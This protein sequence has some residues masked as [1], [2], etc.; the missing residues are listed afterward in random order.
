MAAK[1][2]D[3]LPPPPADLSARALPITI[4]KGPIYRVFRTSCG[5]DYFGK[6]SSERFDDPAQKYGVLYAALQP[7]G[8]FAEVFLRELLLMVLTEQDLMD[9]SLATVAT[10][11]LRCVDLSGEG[12]RT[13]SCDNR[14]ATEKPYKTVGLWSRA[15][16]DHPERPDAILYRSRHNPELH[17]VA[18]F[19]RCRPKLKFKTVIVEELMGARRGWTA[20][21]LE[22]YKLGLVPL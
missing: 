13:I 14:I 22:T 1:K 5:G 12:L 20:D 6:G 18:L 21:Q 11:Q 2:G 7:D 17:C 8:A 15:L 9:R 4:V 3:K 10:R 16:F 19:D